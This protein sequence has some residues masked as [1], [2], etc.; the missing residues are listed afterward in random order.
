[1]KKNNI[2]NKDVIEEIQE[3]VPTVSLPPVFKNEAKKAWEESKQEVLSPKDILKKR[4]QE[5]NAIDGR[6][7]LDEKIRNATQERLGT[8]FP[9]IPNYLTPTVS[10]S[11]T[12]NPRQRIREER[13]SFTSAE[14]LRSRSSSKTSD[15]SISSRD[16]L[17]EQEQDKL[18]RIIFR[19]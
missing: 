9:E 4:R 17:D 18:P 2:S 5:R 15:S 13:F 16:S 3:N 6:D 19:R 8:R 7:A 10:P 11:P 12:E 14:D 1:M